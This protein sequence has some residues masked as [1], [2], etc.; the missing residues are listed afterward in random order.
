MLGRPFGV[1][2]DA[3]FQER[4]LLAA[5][6]LLEAPSGP[7]LAEYAE[8]APATPAEDAGGQVCPIGFAQD[9]HTSDLGALLLRE[10]EALA[11]WH[12]LA[13]ERRGRTAVGLSGVPVETS[14]AVLSAFVNGDSI[15]AGDRL[16]LGEMLKLASEDVRAYYYEAAA[17]KPGDPDAHAI[18]SWFWHE[19]AAG[20][21]FLAFQKRAAASA[22]KSLQRL[23]ATSIVPRAI[24]HCQPK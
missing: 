21:V 3:A 15:A 11:P 23:A 14:A 12:D 6:R 7:V 1:P 8:E 9:A 5:L 4:V 24:L 2:N 20:R 16:S 19:T 13:L 18:Q 22:D 17:A 10:V